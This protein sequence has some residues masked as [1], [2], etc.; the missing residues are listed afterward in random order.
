MEWQKYA[1][2]KNGML[3]DLMPRN[4]PDSLYD[5]RDIAYSADII[6]SDGAKYDLSIKE[7]ISAIPIPTFTS[8]WNTTFELSYILKIRCGAEKDAELI[9]TFVDK[10]LS[11]MQASHM[12]WRSRDYFQVIRNYYRCGLFSEGDA[13]E[14]EFRKNNPHL[15]NDPAIIKHELEHEQTKRYFKKKYEKRTR[16]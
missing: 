14:K 15:F 3:Y 11:L 8:T 1:F 4:N 9:P 7:D 13:F 2:F 5:D 12:L 6:V 10:V 16:T